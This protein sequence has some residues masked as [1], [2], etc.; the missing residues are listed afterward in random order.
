M[1]LTQLDLPEGERKGGVHL[2][3]SNMMITTLSTGVGG[4]GQAEERT[5]RNYIQFKDTSC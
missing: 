4:G 3:P 2:D 1:L 5:E